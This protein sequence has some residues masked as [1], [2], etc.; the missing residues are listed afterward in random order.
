MWNICMSMTAIKIEL[1]FNIERICDITTMSPIVIYP[2]SKNTSK[3][4]FILL[5]LNFTEPVAR[6][7]LLGHY[8]FI[9]KFLDII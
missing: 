2:W 1:L 8:Y 3:S 7:F 6:I 5:L 4:D 9:L